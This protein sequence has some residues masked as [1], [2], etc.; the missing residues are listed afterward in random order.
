MCTSRKDKI[1]TIN[2]AS[3][4]G[5]ID[6]STRAILDAMQKQNENFNKQIELLTRRIE[7]TQRIADSENKR[8]AAKIEHDVATQLGS[9]IT[10]DESVLARDIRPASTRGRQPS[11]L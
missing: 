11:L 3:T 2:T 4:T 5:A 6:N 7:E 10:M 1:E 9:F 8:R